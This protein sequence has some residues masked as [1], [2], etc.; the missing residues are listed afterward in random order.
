MKLKI[1][2]FILLKIRQ[3]LSTAAVPA[4]IQTEH[5]PNI[6]R[7]R[8]FF[9]SLIISQVEKQYNFKQPFVFLTSLVV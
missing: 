4:D 5:L 8:Y 1:I 3:N 6:N 7:E 9:T 2:A